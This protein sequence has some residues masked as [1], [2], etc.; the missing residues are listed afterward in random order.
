[1][2]QLIA[3]PLPA[4]IPATRAAR[5]FRPQRDRERAM[6]QASIMAWTAVLM[7]AFVMVSLHLL[8]TL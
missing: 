5:V 1:M 3:F 8:L 2:G 4:R 6:R 7:T